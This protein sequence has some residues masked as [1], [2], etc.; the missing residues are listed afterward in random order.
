MIK[1]MLVDDEKLIREGLK[2]L[3]SLDEDLEIVA[4]ANSGKDAF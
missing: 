4:E 2:I 3:I 1:I